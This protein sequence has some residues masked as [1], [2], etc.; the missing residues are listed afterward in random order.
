MLIFGGLVSASAFG[1]ACAGDGDGGGGGGGGG[2]GSGVG[3]SAAGGGVL[4][5]V[6][7]E[8]VPIATKSMSTRIRL[9]FII[10]PP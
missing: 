4:Q 5:A 9:L 2:G 3:S 6:T 8:M 7:T 10:K 1:S